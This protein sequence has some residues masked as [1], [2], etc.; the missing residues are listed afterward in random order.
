MQEQ[1]ESDDDNLTGNTT[2]HTVS[3]VWVCVYLDM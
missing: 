3:I 1:M 2:Y